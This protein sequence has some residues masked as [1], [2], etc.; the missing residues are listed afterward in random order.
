MLWYLA[1]L[2]T[3]L[4]GLGLLDHRHK[5]AI[6]GGYPLRTALTLVVGVAFFLA[7]D[8][9]GIRSGVFFRGAGPYQ[10]GVLLAPELPLEE[11]FFLTVL[12][13]V[14]LLSYL[15]G[16]RFLERRRSRR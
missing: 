7:W 14:S 1:A 13:Y 6:F 16:Q 8:L 3:S 10:T 12:C 11:V 5:L 15:A 2:L 4:V 9:V